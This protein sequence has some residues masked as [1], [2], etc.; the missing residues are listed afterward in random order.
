MPPD[1]DPT[2]LVY[3]KHPQVKALGGP[4]TRESIDY[5]WSRKG[6]TEAS[7]KEVAKAEQAAADAALGTVV[8]DSKGA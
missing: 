3:I 8:T 5:L 4:V 1:P 6:W 2:E 7:P